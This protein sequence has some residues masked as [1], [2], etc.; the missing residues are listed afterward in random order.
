MEKSFNLSDSGKCF[1]PIH[2]LAAGQSTIMDGVRINF[3]LLALRMK[4]YQNAC[5]MES[6][7]D[8]F[9][10]FDRW[11]IVIYKYLPSGKCSIISPEIL[12][13]YIAIL[14]FKCISAYAEEHY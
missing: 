9:C 10:R 1:S 2:F 7:L 5:V 11:S 8:C 14:F 13:K 3:S 6:M 12:S 4:S